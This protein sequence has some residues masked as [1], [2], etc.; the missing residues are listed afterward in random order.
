MKKSILLIA[1]LTFLI[2][3][4]GSSEIFDDAYNDAKAPE[5]VKVNE[6]E[7]YADYI[8]NE[9]HKYP[10]EVED[11]EK[12]SMDG[13]NPSYY[14]NNDYYDPYGHNHQEPHG[15]GGNNSGYYNGYNQYYSPN[16]N[17]LYCNN[18]YGTGYGSW[19]NN[20]GYGSWNS[21]AVCPYSCMTW[22][23]TG[24]CWHLNRYDYYG[25]GA[26]AYNNNFYNGSYGPG[27]SYYYGYYNPNNPYGWGSTYGSY[28]GNGYY[29]G[30][31]Y[32][33]NY[34]YGNSWGSPYGY[35]G[36]GMPY[37]YP[38]WGNSFNY[39]GGSG[40]NGNNNEDIVS[41]G[42]HHYGH[43]GGSNSGSYS[44]NNTTY[45]HTVKGPAESTPFPSYTAHQEN[46]LA[47]EGG[48][49]ISKPTN[50]TVIHGNQFQKETP[51]HVNTY[52]ADEQPGTFGSSK[53][54]QNQG[55]STMV[56]KPVENTG[57]SNFATTASKDKPS[58]GTTVVTSGK[59][60][61]NQFS[62]DGNRPNYSTNTSGSSRGG[63]SGN[64]TTYTHPN[65]Y[66]NY[67]GNTGYT[68]PNNSGTTYGG[69]TN[70]D[71]RRTYNSGSNNGTYNNRNGSS[72]SSNRSGSTTYSGNR[73]SSSSGSSSSRSGS[74]GSSGGTSSRRK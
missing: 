32:Y 43:R 71:S 12:K 10:V 24:N 23:N 57:N 52:S 40:W 31:G 37:G 73:S 34:Y 29:C 9:E 54:V 27:G 61:N 59:P 44:Q 21:W 68:R 46:V 36:W 62:S 22:Y 45:T 15:F 26:Y 7:G 69:K 53:P 51:D 16:S 35:N 1:P 30:N 3:C 72:N 18:M 11:T 60:A 33:N 55:N 20:N 64:N 58:V 41:N 70:S 42:N 13:I 28:Y 25:G 66:G 50:S 74:S 65:K 47:N 67:N 2:S 48:N 6:E 38:Y 4:T 17:G 19:N 39:G 14:G 49:D 63:G 5:V 56:N 8:K